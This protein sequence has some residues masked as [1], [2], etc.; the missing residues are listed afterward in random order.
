[1]TL[2][3]AGHPPAIHVTS[4]GPVQLGGGAVLGAWADAPIPSHEVELRGRRDPGPRHRR[5]VRGRAAGDARRRPRRWASS[6]TR[7]ADLELGEM[8][9][10]L[11]QDA[12]ARSGGRLRDDLVLLAIRPGAD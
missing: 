12:I 2:A 10:C 7:F 1:M 11:R 5:L 9:E 4:E 3:A 6:P 8:T